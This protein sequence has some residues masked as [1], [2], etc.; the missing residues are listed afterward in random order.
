MKGYCIIA[1]SLLLSVLLVIGGC[2]TVTETVTKT[3]TQP[4]VTVT[5]TASGGTV[6]NTVTQPASTVTVTSTAQPSTS[7]TK[8]TTTTTATSTTKTTTTT[9][10]TS[11][12]T[13][14]TQPQT[15]TSDDGKLQIIKHDFIRDLGY[16]KVSGTVKNISSATVSA[17]VTVEYYDNLGALLD[18]QTATL[19]DITAGGVKAFSCQTN[20]GLAFNHY[21][22]SIRS[23]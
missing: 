15:I 6:T 21:V 4:A 12:A 20:S 16:V 11:T 22:I 13:A 3:T 17:E 9:S 8:T 7:T 14:T 19:E 23:I 10:A 2:K 5:S 1:V 18:T